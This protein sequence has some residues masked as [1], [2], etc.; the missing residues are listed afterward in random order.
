MADCLDRAWRYL[1][2]TQR[3][4]SCARLPISDHCVPA[5]GHQQAIGTIRGQLYRRPIW[6]SATRFEPKSLSLLAAPDFGPSGT[7]IEVPTHLSRRELST[8]RPAARH[9]TA[10]RTSRCCPQVR[11][12]FLRRRG[13]APSFWTRSTG[14]TIRMQCFHVCRLCESTGPW[15]GGPIWTVGKMASHLM[16]RQLGATAPATRHLRTPR[17]PNQI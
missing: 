7:S 12:A 15:H 8:T 3:T 6:D 11:G 5:V 16:L 13:T 2:R 1:R 14:M 9:S 4:N 10:R 17:S